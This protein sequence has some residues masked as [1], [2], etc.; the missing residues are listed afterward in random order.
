MISTKG[1]RGTWMHQEVWRCAGSSVST[2]RR[3]SQLQMSGVSIPQSHSLQ[4]PAACLHDKS[5]V[6]LTHGITA[7]RAEAHTGYM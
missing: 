3:C 7:T 5:S 6:Q 2:L 4:G 1:M